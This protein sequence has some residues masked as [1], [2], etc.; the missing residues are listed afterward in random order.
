MF[1]IVTCASCKTDE[2]YLVKEYLNYLAN[3]TGIGGSDDINENFESLINWKIVISSDYDDKILSL[4]Q[5]E[6]EEKCT[7]KELC[8]KYHIIIT[9]RL[10]PLRNL[11]IP[12]F[13]NQQ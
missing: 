12:I 9:V 1:I 10:F 8:D 6:L 3:T 13:P 2:P 5:A 7:P 4:F 11:L